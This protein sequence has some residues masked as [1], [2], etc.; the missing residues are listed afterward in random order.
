MVRK[1]TLY[2]NKWRTTSTR[3]NQGDIK[4]APGLRI[5][6]PGL[7]ASHL[8]Q[9]TCTRPMMRRCRHRRISAYLGRNIVVF[10][11]ELHELLLQ[12]DRGIVGTEHFGRESRHQL[13][14]ILVQD[15]SVEAVEEV[16]AALSQN[17]SL[18]TQLW[19]LCT[20]RSSMALKQTKVSS[21]SPS[22]SP[23]R[24]P[25]SCRPSFPQGRNC[26][27]WSSPCQESRTRRRR[28]A[29]QETIP[30]RT[31]KRPAPCRWSLAL[32]AFI[33]MAKNLSASA[34]RL[35]RGL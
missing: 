17:L 35:C 32:P 15:G 1:N 34:R 13:I 25:R 16:V 19:I 29:L 26:C 2:D 3:P 11:G 10:F 7:K 21:N 33:F 20:L 5:A 22:Y 28:G 8:R 31:R 27:I 18:F 30:I 9:C 24:E 4:P 23:W 12:C 6:N 14:Q